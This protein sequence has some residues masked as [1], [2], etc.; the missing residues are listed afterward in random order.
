M[1]QL[2]ASKV[3]LISTPSFSKTNPP[4][5]DSQFSLILISP[6]SPFAFNSVFNLLNNFFDTIF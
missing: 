2:R 1:N 6:L 4:L 5:N 3:L